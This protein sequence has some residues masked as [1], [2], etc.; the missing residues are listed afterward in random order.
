M[1]QLKLDSGLVSVMVILVVILASSP[2]TAVQSR[3]HL[4]DRRDLAETINSL[5]QNKDSNN[6]SFKSN[7]MSDSDYDQEEEYNDVFRGDDEGNNVVNDGEDDDYF[8]FN[9]RVNM[10][11]KRVVV[12]EDPLIQVCI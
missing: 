7:E 2:F 9:R 3:V 11:V 10:E 6:F 8:D 5:T 4:K 12:T 1:R